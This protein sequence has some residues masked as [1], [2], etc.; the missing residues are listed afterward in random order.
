MTIAKS[1]T[2][3]IDASLNYK[4]YRAYSADKPCQSQQSGRLAI[5][6]VAFNL[7]NSKP[8]NALQFEISGRG[9][10]EMT[11]DTLINLIIAIATI[12][13]IVVALITWMASSADAK[14]CRV[15]DFYLKQKRK[16]SAR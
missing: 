1:I 4:C 14:R 2:K 9:T 11:T 3:G 8:M 16:R 5:S 10:S 7:R 6:F 12:A 15:T 13:T